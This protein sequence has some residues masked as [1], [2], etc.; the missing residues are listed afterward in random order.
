MLLLLL[1]LLLHAAARPG[2]VATLAN[3]LVCS[4]RSSSNTGAFRG[5][6]Q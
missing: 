6:Q 5:R 2:A 1:L 3:V 4:S